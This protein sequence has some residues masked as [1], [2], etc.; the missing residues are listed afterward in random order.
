M[1]KI[2]SV[3]Q[4]RQWDLFTLKNEPIS[5]IDL[6]ERAS[7]AFVNLFLTKV[8]DRPPVDVVCG[9]G[10]NG[11]D[12]F[13]IARLLKER[14]L[15]VNCHLIDL[16]STLSDDCEVNYRKFLKIGEVNIIKQS[17]DLK[18]SGSLIIDAVFGSGLNRP[19]TGL[20]A[21]VIHLI[22][23]AKAKTIAVDVPSG[24]FADQINLSG[25]IIEADWTIT[26]QVPKLSFLIPESGYYVGQWSAVDIGLQAEFLEE[27]SSDYFLLEQQDIDRSIFNRK[28]F[29]HK[30][31]YGRVLIVAGSLGKMGAAFLSA[32]AALKSGAGLLT[33]HIP[34]AGYAPIQTSLPEAMVSLDAEHEFIS[35]IAKVDEFDV[36]GIGPGLGVHPKTGE[37]LKKL[38]TSF[39]RP[40]VIDAD[41]LNLI[42][43]DKELLNLIPKGSVLTPHVG[44]F[45]RLFGVCEDGLKRIEKIKLMAIEKQLVIV[46]KG[47]H[48]AIATPKGQVFFNSTGNSG[49]ATAGCG[50]VLT[51]IISAFI[52]QGADTS[53]SAKVGV[54]IHGWAGDLAENTVGKTA[55][56]ASDLLCVLPEIIRNVESIDFI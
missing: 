2:L 34:K 30:G 45:N 23:Q 43:L 42:A 17:N 4:I 48:S 27:V 15:E 46:L 28:K 38:F 21:E 50:D 8:T 44:E 22:N 3:E 54:Y 18:L 32:K 52:A 39:N 12:G 29:D 6:M 13:A 25:K 16:G 14:G 7:E 35:D 53:T 37:M 1:I 11:G 55:L 49:M 5:A 19:V 51:G 33:V 40:M 31:K 20:A 47:A 10:N 36:I 56:M 9:P 26:F 24:L 41:A